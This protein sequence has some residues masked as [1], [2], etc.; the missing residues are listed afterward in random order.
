MVDK[1]FGWENLWWKKLWKNHLVGK[2]FGEKNVN[3]TA[4]VT[5]C[6]CNKSTARITMSLKKCS[7]WGA[8]GV[9]NNNNS[10][11]NNK[12]VT[13]NWNNN[14]SD[15]SNK[16]RTTNNNTRFCLYRRAC[17]GIGSASGKG[18]S[19]VFMQLRKVCNHPYLFFDDRWPSDLV[20]Y[21]LNSSK[22]TVQ[23]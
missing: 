4:T 17:Q 15:S 16:Q 14:N 6:S 23:Q 12:Y 7:R 21:A 22:Q 1:Y 11:N 19:N 8:G 5:T 2:S 13:A 20:S 3:A 9:C 18:L 10:N